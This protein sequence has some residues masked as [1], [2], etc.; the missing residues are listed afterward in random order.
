MNKYL[1]NL[2][3]AFAKMLNQFNTDFE[4]DIEYMEEWVKEN[5]KK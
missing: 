5:W 2:Y 3:R 4:M 1:D